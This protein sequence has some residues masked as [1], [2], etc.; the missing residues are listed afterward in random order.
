MSP[1][2]K[3]TGYGAYMIAANHENLPGALEGVRVLDLAEPLGALVGRILGDLG[4][5]V[6]KIEP[7]GGDP[8][9]QLSP[10]LRAGQECLSLPFVHANVNKR[11]IV[12]DLDRR[13]G[14]EHFRELLEQA[15]VVVST[16]GIATWATRGIDLERL[17]RLYPRLVW[18]AFSIFGLSG[19]HSAYIG[20]NIVAEAM[21]GLSYIQGDDAKPP[22][23]SPYEQGRYLASLH[24]AFGTLLALW[25]RHVSGQGQVV[26]TCVQEVLANLYFLLV[27]YGLWSDIPYRIGAR[28]FMPPNGYYP[29]QDGHVFIATLMPRLWEKLVEVVGDPRLADAALQEP[30]Y[31]NEHPELVDPILQEYTARFDRWSLTTKL[32]RHGIPAAPWST[33]ADVAL[34][35]HLHQRGFFIDFEQPPFGCLRSSGPMFRASASP[36]RIRR[37]APQPGE[38]QQEG[39][40]E[41]SSEAPSA[42]MQAIVGTRRGLP[43]A[44]IRIL[45][46]SRAWAGPYGTRYLAD[47][48]ADVIKVETGKYPDGRQPDSPS[49]GEVNRNKRPITLNFQMPE[50]R[51]L[52]KRLVAVSDVVVENFSPRVMAKYELDYPHLLEV[53]PDLI[54]VSLPGFGRSGPHGGFVSFGG[55]LMAYTGMSLLWGYA[56]SPPNTRVKIA[57]PDY[58]VASTQ[59]LAVTAALHHRARTGQGQHIEIAQVEATIAAM[60]LAYLEYFANGTVATPRGNRDPNA[61]P[62]GCYPCVGHEAWCVISCTTDAQWHTLARLIGDEALATDPGLATAAERWKRHDELDELISAWTRDWTPYQLM[63]ALQAAGVPAGMVQTAE[64]LWRDIHLRARDYNVMMAHPEL[65][66][67]EHPGMTVGLHATPGHIQRPVGRLGE[68]NDAVFRG[69]LGL[70]TQELVRLIKAGVIA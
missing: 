36:L 3:T 30:E 43:L 7:P 59:A 37:P 42:P 21:G 27:S 25:E 2:G 17:S 33:V 26:E 47:F 55:P 44:G 19:P 24:A 67:V 62:Q 38:H 34:N 53:R 4:A 29:C 56:D 58:I 32:Q 64:D 57:Q 48:G 23:V 51:E 20:N 61:V 68:A 52:L 13:E 69:L 15:D 1:S 46:L 14:Q 12:L 60:E 31:R 35:E 41:T 40:A 18:T 65:G 66:M 45:D 28:N 49:Y 10:F 63:R 8:G 11:S 22:C 39:F 54:M 9:R 6:I 70:S 5:D 16:A 50:G